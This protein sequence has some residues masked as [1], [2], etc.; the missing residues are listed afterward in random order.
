L[1]LIAFHTINASRVSYYLYSLIN[2]LG[3]RC[4]LF[5]FNCQL[6]ISN[7]VSK[8]VPHQTVSQF[9]RMYIHLQNSCCS[10]VVVLFERNNYVSN[11]EI[12]KSNKD[13]CNGRI[14]A[15]EAEKRGQPPKK[16]VKKTT[17]EQ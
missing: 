12:I 8:G 13:S 9:V 16:R 15:I 10:R 6:V 14:V 2:Q 17:H 4:C 5:F 7:C 3:N 1:L 11:M